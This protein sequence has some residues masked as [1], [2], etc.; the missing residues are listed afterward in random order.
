MKIYDITQELFSS[1]VFPG[2]PSPRGRRLAS[3][4]EGDLCN[5]TE[6]SMCAHNGTHIDAPCH[7]IEGGAAIDEIPL[8]STVGECFVTHFD[9][10]VTEADAV[11]ILETAKSFGDEAAKRIL[12]GGRAT[13]SEE[14][15]QIFADSGILLIGNESQTVGPEDAP[16]STN[17]ILLGAGVILLE[18]V[19]LG[20]VPK[21]RYL[22]FASPLLLSGSDGSPC[23]AVLLEI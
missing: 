20:Q 5:V 10:T 12:I 17:L 18:G 13:V 22:L 19:R 7:F 3:I 9:G 21:G 23:R 1:V 15:A 16:M 4:S 2:D 6:L 11:G 14:A 8:E